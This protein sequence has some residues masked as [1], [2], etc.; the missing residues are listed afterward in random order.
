MKIC[1]FSA[2]RNQLRYAHFHELSRK[3]PEVLSLKNPFAIVEMS[4]AVDLN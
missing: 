1:V 2:S 3:M 4:F